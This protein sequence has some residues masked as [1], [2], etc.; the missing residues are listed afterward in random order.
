MNLYT[1]TVHTFKMGLRNLSHILSVSEEHAINTNT[2]PSE[3]LEA[4]LIAD[5]F[6]LTYQVQR[7][8]DHAIACSE[9]V[10]KQRKQPMEDTESTFGELQERIRKTLDY[11]AEIDEEEYLKGAAEV[12]EIKYK[13]GPYDVTQTKLEYILE[14]TLPNFWFHAAT[15]HDILR[16]KGVPIGKSDFIFG[17]KR[18]S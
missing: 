7:V 1:L 8:S 13:A 16:M 6:P 14:S 2:P 4:R 12:T 15:A 11:L 3:Y 10:G 18:M 17:K 9:R 5:M